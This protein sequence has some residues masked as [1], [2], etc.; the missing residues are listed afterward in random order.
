MKSY[1]WFN[2]TRLRDYNTSKVHD[3]K[4]S[5][6]N[7]GGCFGHPMSFLCHLQ[8]R[9]ELDCMRHSIVSPQLENPEVRDATSMVRND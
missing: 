4:T 3:E 9:Q 5:W 1:C 7:M 8:L 6:R 2:E